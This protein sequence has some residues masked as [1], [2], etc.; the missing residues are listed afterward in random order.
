M[1]ETKRVIDLKKEELEQELQRPNWNQ[2]KLKIR[3]LQESIERHK[4]WEYRKSRKRRR[5]KS[6]RN[7]RGFK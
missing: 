5:T 3:R 4:E 7:E 2:N 6:K 1:G